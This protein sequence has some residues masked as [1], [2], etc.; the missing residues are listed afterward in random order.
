MDKTGDRLFRMLLQKPEQRM[1][2]DLTKA[3]TMEWKRHIQEAL[4]Y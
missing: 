1:T 3:V 2:M 4:R